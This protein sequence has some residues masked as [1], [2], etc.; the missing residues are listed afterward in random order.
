MRLYLNDENV[1]GEGY[2]L[3]GGEFPGVFQQVLMAQSESHM[4]ILYTVLGGKDFKTS[5][6]HVFNLAYMTALHV[7]I[8]V[9]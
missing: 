7:S 5:L 1:K 9:V 2:E 4:S 3:G 6:T 8:P